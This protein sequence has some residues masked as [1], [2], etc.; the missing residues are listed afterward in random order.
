MQGAAMA[1]ARMRAQLPPCDDELEAAA[2]ALGFA[3]A[4][5]AAPPPSAVAP[6]APLRVAPEAPSPAGQQLGLQPCAAL[7]AALPQQLRTA[8]PP[9]QQPLQLAMQGQVPSSSLL[10]ALLE[11]RFW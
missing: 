7:A 3:P 8:L 4:A 2:G 6:A 9:P 5:A 1:L 10:H 11:Q